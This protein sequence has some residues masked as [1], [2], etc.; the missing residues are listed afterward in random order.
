MMQLSFGPRLIHVAKASTEFQLELIELED[1]N[2][3]KSLS[4]TRKDPTEVW[5]MQCCIQACA[6]MYNVFFFVLEVLLF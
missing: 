1:D 4:D 3:I 5:K 2:V 6:N